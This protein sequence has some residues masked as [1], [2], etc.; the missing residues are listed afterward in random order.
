MT[1][2]PDHLTRARA[3]D[4]ERRRS[5]VLK[6]LDQLAARGEEISVSAVARTAGSTTA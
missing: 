1:T 6:A 4:S 2:S 5:R 3:A